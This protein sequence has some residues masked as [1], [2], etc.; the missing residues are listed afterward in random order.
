MAPMTGDYRFAMSCDRKCE[1]YM[2]PSDKADKKRKIL[3][4][5][6]KT[7]RHEFGRYEKAT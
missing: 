3:E 7:A 4:L 2:S 5:T 1:F 6:K